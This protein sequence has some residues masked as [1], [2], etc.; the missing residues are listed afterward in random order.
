VK[1]FE[2][3]RRRL[4]PTAGGV[5]LVARAAC[6]SRADD[7][8][9]EA[10][11]VGDPLTGTLCVGV[12]PTISP[13][14]LPRLTPALRERYPKLTTLWIEDKTEALTRRLAGGELDAAILALEADIA[15]AS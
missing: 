5:Q 7:L 10:R 15:F 9:E 8:I 13:H 2:R 4:L 3:D 12:I 14:L 11:R 1:L 6:W